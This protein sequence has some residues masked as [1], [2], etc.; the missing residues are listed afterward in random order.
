MMAKVNTIRKKNVIRYNGDPC[1]VLECNIRTP[2]NMAAFC[3]MALRN[4][5]FGK[6]IHLRL[7]TGES[8]EILD[9]DAR[10][11]EFS[12][13]N[14]G[15]YHFLDNETYETYEINK[16]MIEDAINYLVPNQ[17]YEV[18]FVDGKPLTINLPSAVDI[19]VTESPDGVRGDSANNVQKTVVLE[20]GLSIQV[21]LFIKQGEIVRINTETNSYLG[22]A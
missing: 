22:R 12:Y 7:S 10:K 1:L 4:L 18:F 21:P 15:V 3:Q 19:K 13:E 16:D 2:P 6:A 5:V 20:T 8:F 11:A 14:Q 17:S 9:T